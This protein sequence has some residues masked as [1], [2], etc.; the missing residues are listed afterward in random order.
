MPVRNTEEALEVIEPDEVVIHEDDVNHRIQQEVSTYCAFIAFMCLQCFDA[1]FGGR[2]GIRPVK[3]LSG[4]VLAWL[5]VWSE[6]QTCIWP[7]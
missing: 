4:G 3:K 2:K 7:S 1:G 5:C 6:V